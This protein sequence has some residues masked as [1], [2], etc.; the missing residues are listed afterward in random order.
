[1]NELLKTVSNRLRYSYDKLS[2]YNIDTDKLLYKWREYRIP[3]GKAVT[4]YKYIGRSTFFGT[5]KYKVICENIYY[6]HG[7]RR[8][9]GT[10]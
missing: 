8:E 7:L 3:Y 6:E 9:I 10:G 5:K 1:M 4:L 2:E